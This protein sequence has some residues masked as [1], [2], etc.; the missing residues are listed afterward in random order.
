M[1]DFK[2]SLV[3]LKKSI[4]MKQELEDTIGLATSYLNIVTNLRMEKK[5]TFIN[6]YL[7]TAK[8]YVITLNNPEI[9]VYYFE[10]VFRYYYS[11]G[12]LKN[13]DVYFDKYKE[14]KD[15]LINKDITKQ[16]S[17]MSVKYDTEQI[18]LES[19]NKQ[20]QFEHERK[21]KNVF[22][23]F[24]ICICVLLVV[25]I[26]VLRKIK[27]SNVLIKTQQKE[28][29]KAYSEMFAQK[30]IIEEKQ[31]EILDSIHYAKRIQTALLP[32]DKYIERNLNDLQK[33]D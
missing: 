29:V 26:L 9:E 18:K 8:K 3:Y 14:A 24:S 21:I 32:S 22:T 33:K 12:D 25:L 4:K 1:N 11:I 16:L 13:A 15:S 2:K 20:K 7:D 23:I 30:E 5:Y 19:L 17:D 28:L 10:E 6:L 31:R 27:A